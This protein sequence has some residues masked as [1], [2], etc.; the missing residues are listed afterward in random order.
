VAQFIGAGGFWYWGWVN[1]CIGAGSILVL[2]LGVYV[3]RG[4]VDF[5]IGA[6]CTWV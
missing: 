1:L 5:G 2:G 3:Y 6:G 4:W